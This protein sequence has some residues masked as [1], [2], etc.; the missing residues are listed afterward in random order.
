MNREQVIATLREHERELKAAG[1]LHLAVFGSVAR[2]DN[3]AASDV[4]LLA[5]FDPSR[6]LTLVAIGRMQSQL[7]D[8]LQARVDLS[9]PGWLRESIRARVVAEAVDAF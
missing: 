7:T 1:V 5:E 3:S 2:G 8:W 9:T 4:D 6:R